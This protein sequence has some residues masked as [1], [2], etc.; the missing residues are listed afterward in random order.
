VIRELI[1]RYNRTGCSSDTCYRT[2][3]DQNPVQVDSNTGSDALTYQA[4]SVANPF[5][6]SLTVTDARGSSASTS[7]GVNPAGYGCGY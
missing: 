3:A 5:P 1:E 2:P 4:N 6:I 7:L